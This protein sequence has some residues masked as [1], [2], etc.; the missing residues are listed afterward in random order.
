MIGAHNH[1]DDEEERQKENDKED[2]VLGRMED[3]LDHGDRQK[4]KK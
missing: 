1:H 3:V 2:G 4:S